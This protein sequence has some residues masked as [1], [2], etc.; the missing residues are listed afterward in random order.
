MPTLDFLK[1]KI[2]PEILVSRG[3]K[4]IYVNNE[5]NVLKK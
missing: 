2:N 1:L 5:N 4:W 3:I